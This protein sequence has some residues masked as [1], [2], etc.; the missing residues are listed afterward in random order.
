MLGGEH[1]GRQ[2]KDGE[3][4]RVHRQHLADV[5]RRGDPVH[6]GH[7]EVHQHQVDRLSVGDGADRLAPVPGL[8]HDHAPGLQHATGHEPVGGVVL[9]HQDADPREVGRYGGCRGRL[10]GRLGGGRKPGP[11]VGAEGAAL[12]LDALHR[13]VPVLPLDEFLDDGEPQAG[14]AE[15]A[16]GV[17]GGLHE[18]IEDGRLAIGRDAD[19][20]IG[21]LDVEA[22]PL[23]LAVGA[24]CDADAPVRG[25]LDG[26]RG[27]VEEHLAQARR[28]PEEGRGEVGGDR[29][30]QQDALLPGAGVEHLADLLDDLG[31]GVGDRLDGELTGSEAGEVEQVVDE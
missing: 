11:Q 15:P 9:H 20:R 14:A 13:D 3:R 4:V 16:R 2:R 1:G 17:A 23:G 27:Q 19:S 31:R 18:R 28:V 30:L 7:L 24:D 29:D 21:H 25:E 5:S 6:L 8:G 22:G 26:V 10:R 12:A